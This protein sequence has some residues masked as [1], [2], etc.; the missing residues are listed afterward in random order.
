[1]GLVAFQQV[2]S[3]QTRDGT[4][5]SRTGRQTPYHWATRDAQNAHFN[6]FPKSLRSTALHRNTRLSPERNR[7]KADGSSTWGPVPLFSLTTTQEVLLSSVQF[8]RSVV[9]D[10]LQP[11]DCSA[12]GFP[13]HHQLPELAQTHVHRVGD[14]VSTLVSECG[15][16][17]TEMWK[18]QPEPTQWASEL[19]PGSRQPRPAAPWALLPPQHPVQTQA[20]GSWQNLFSRLWMLVSAHISF[21]ASPRQILT[22]LL[23]KDWI[24]NPKS[25]LQKCAFAFPP[26]LGLPLCQWIHISLSV[27]WIYTAFTCSECFRIL[28]G[29]AVGI[30]RNY[31]WKMGKLDLWQVVGTQWALSSFLPLSSDHHWVP[32]GHRPRAGT[33]AGTRQTSCGPASL[34]LFSGWTDDQMI[35]TESKH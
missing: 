22:V 4:H 1:M 2:G 25:R 24:W 15:I 20:L 3:S 18:L 35:H 26:N 14:A 19:L 28:W 7:C 10:S 32:T 34:Q 8:S 12:A 9:S 13:V 33:Q 31:K 27:K 21:A 6:K 5:A 17:D 16:S 23:G 30:K 11:L 29:Q